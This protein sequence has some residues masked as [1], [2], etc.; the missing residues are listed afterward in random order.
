MIP[1]VESKGLEA[2]KAA[3]LTLIEI[4]GEQPISNGMPEHAA[5]LYEC[6]F[7]KAQSE[8][9][10][11]CDKLAN[12][13]FGQRG[14]LTKAREA[15]ARNVSIDILTRFKPEDGPFLDLA[16]NGE[17]PNLRVI[18]MAQAPEVNFAVVDGKRYR[19]EENLKEFRAVACM[20]AP[21][22]SAILAKAF[23]AL[24]A[25]ASTT[26]LAGA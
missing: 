9:L 19:Y 1:V 21:D 20:N 18:H 24:F 6:F 3:I 7:D 11:L 16:R 10:I 17:F 2:Y 22:V 13:V 8:V 23:K 26:M 5:I 25:K 12:E 14:V 4:D 15:L